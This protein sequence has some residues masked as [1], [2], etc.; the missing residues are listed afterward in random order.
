MNYRIIAADNY[1]TASK[2]ITELLLKTD[3]SDLS[4]GHIVISNDRCSMS[5]ELELL[6]VLGGS[7]NTR[8]LTFAR[9]TSAIMAEKQFI[10]KQS[11]IML[12]GKLAAQLCDSLSCYKKSY[13]TAGFA[14]S[15][16]D[17][18]SQLKYSAVEPGDI[19][20]DSY[21]VNLRAKMRDVKLIYAAYE[22]FIRD[23]YVDSGAKL[24][25]LIARAGQSDLIKNS[26]FYIKDFDNF[27]TQ[28]IL[29]IRQL[30][31][32][33]K[34]VTVAVPYVP[35]DDRYP[36]DAFEALLNVAEG[37][38]TDADVTYAVDNQS[39]FV[40]EIFQSLFKYKTSFEAKDAE[41]KVRVKKE[42]DVFAETEGVAAYIRDKVE[43]GARYK[44]FLIVAGDVDKYAYAVDRIFAK[45]DVPYFLD[46]KA[47][48]SEHPLC[49]LLTDLFAVKTGGYDRDSCLSLAKNFFYGDGSDVD[50]FENYCLKNNLLYFS[51]PF[52]GDLP[53]D[54]EA[55]EAR[56]RLVSFVDG[57]GLDPKDKVSGYVGKLKALIQSDETRS[58]LQRLMTAEEITYPSLYKVSCQTEEKT[59]AV[60][61]TLEGLFGED[62]VT[63]ER[64]SDM[65]KTGFESTF[66]SLIPLY[67]DCVVFTTVA[68][69]R[70][71]G[72]KNLIVMGASDGEFPSVRRDTKIISDDDIDKLKKD[73]VC[74][75]P[76][77]ES[78]NRREKFN[79]FQLL[80]APRESLYL[81]Y[82][83]GGDNAA[84]CLAAEEISAMFDLR[85]SERDIDVLS[86]V[87]CE[88]QAKERFVEEAALYMDGIN[89]A[90]PRAA[91]LY[92]ALKDKNPGLR[93][94]LYSG[95]EKPNIAGGKDIL[96]PRGKTSVTKME[97]FYRCP[98][99]YFLT[100]GLK[101]KERD[102]GEL[103]PLDTGSIL[104]AVLENFVRDYFINGDGAVG[105]ISEAVTPLVEQTLSQAQYAYVKK[106]PGQ[107]F[108]LRRIQKEAV[109]VCRAVADMIAASAF[110]PKYVELP[111]G[112]D[113][114]AAEGRKVG[115][116]TLVGKIDRIDQCGRKFILLDYKTG[117]AKFDESQL[118]AGQKLQLITY[119]AVAEK[120]T[121]KKCGGFFYM[122]VHD[123]FAEGARYG[124][125]GRVLD[126]GAT[127][128]EIDLNAEAGKTSD[129]LG[130][131]I[132]KNGSISK[133]SNAGMT[134]EQLEV[135]KK[136]TAVM[137]DNAARRME[138]GFI[139]ARPYADACK[140]CAYAAACDYADLDGRENKV[141]ADM[142]TLTEA[143]KNV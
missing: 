78:Q 134:E 60:L 14:Q 113:G 32:Y 110:K 101:A 119:V 40:G 114:A 106:L 5:A 18:I 33:S 131:G 135:Y 8:V 132:N 104:H 91:T 137:L 49:V 86:A 7:F 142:D 37:L 80:T 41:G 48:L 111:F 2:R 20:P 141:K 58:R 45:Y 105:D 76:T 39:G 63:A 70:A 121:G 27:S 6:D 35:G 90:L 1:A 72:N 28:E 112:F 11:A 38:K 25:E 30:V 61:D 103:K 17:A 73:G 130:C 89:S 128:F 52:D 57:V 82:V 139:A 51:S 12:I 138:E 118:Y 88:K 59:L 117:A 56:R 68:K 31:M 115:D 83:A 43:K 24:K 69:A 129:T 46:T 124:Y 77:T 122:P 116:V 125:K 64:F 50:V 87:Y 26:Y 100:Y 62:V 109:A 96:L 44:D 79:V 127:A 108:A 16:Y 13:D 29:I 55:E 9:L 107:V 94:F 66:I 65:L 81:S 92:A 36:S 15:M 120:F 136:Y 99:C 85:V 71:N 143:I 10:S 95:G 74:V 126:D 102:E 84:P 34:G 97:Q 42:S 23:S 19:N 54:K 4:V 67:N 93:E 98:Y 140:Y 21:D 53:E 22:D 75:T 47:A 133:K 3:Q 123:K